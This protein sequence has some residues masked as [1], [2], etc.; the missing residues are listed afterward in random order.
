VAETWCVVLVGARAAGKSTLARALASRLGWPRRDGDE[1]LAELVGRPAG[2]HL[3]RVGE[4]RFRAVEEEVTL[5]A[6]EPGDPRILALGGGAPTSARVRDA[7]RQQGVL[8]V[9]LDAEAA[10]LARRQ[11]RS[12]GR[13]PLTSLPLEEEVE[14]LLR[15]RR[16]VYECVADLRVKSDSANV[17]ACCEAIVARMKLR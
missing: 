3:A 2:D 13:P 16:P 6:L 17:D 1:L 5:R 8:V 12:G 15:E 11:R 4:A 9:F 10:E 14:E 7:L